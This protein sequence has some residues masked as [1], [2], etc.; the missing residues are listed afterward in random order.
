MR[1]KVLL[2]AAALAAGALSTMA[3][4][5]VYSLNIVGYVNYTQPANS[6]RIAANPLNQTNNDV[7]YLF[8]TAASY[9]GLT[10]YKRNSAGTGYDS[11]TFDPDF[12][13]WS[14]PLSVKPGDGVWINTP[15]GIPFTNTFVGEVVLDSTNAVPA[16]YSLKGSVVPQAGLIQTTLGYPT[17]LGDS[18]YIW[19]G[20]GYDTSTFDPDF[21]TWSPSEPS[22]AVA[23]GFW[24][25]N[26]AAAKSWIR[27][28][29]P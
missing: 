24:I 27:H 4:S 28:F 6:Y 5:N 15:A 26:N 22:I 8:P 20:I 25:F 29:A 10:I 9:P 14:S 11:S 17:D 21:A 1:T 18:I 23:Q 16:G 13:V 3:Q 19:N 2:C 7:Q 12:L